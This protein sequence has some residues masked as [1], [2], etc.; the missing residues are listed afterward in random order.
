MQMLSPIANLIVSMEEYLAVRGHRSYF[1]VAIP[2]SLYRKLFPYRLI[3][4]FHSAF[5]L[6]WFSQTPDHVVDKQSVMHK[7]GRVFIQGTKEGS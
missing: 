2:A 5:S 1:V 4:L 3:N 6:H 7:E